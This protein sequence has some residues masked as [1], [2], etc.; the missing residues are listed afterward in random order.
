M[1]PR[2]ASTELPSSCSGSTRL[3]AACG[4]ITTFT[5]GRC[6]T[7]CWKC[8]SA[9]IVAGSVIGPFGLVATIWNGASQPGPIALSISSAST[10]AGASLASCSGLGGPSFSPTAGAARASRI[11]PITQAASSGRRSAP[12]TKRITAERSALCGLPIRQRFTPSPTRVR[13]AGPTTVATVTLRTTT[14]ATVPARLTSSEPGRIS[15]ET[16]I[17]SSSVEPAKATVRPAWRLV[18]RAASTGSAPAASSS[19]KRDTIK[20]RVVDA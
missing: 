19:R 13:I 10:R 6:A 4:P 14:I 3:V 17:E 2:E 18:L 20:Q 9:A 16:S 12:L 7:L 15:S 1:L 8:S 11:A 5:P